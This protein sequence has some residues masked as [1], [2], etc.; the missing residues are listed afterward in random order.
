MNAFC[1]GLKQACAY[2]LCLMR[3]LLHFVGFRDDR[4]WNAVKVWGVPDMI[5][6]IWDRY[7]ADDVAP[8]DVVIFANGPDDQPPR[9]IPRR[10]AVK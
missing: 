8:G 3:P 9:C 6:E 2:C 10:P 5:H 7:G 1:V 4:Y